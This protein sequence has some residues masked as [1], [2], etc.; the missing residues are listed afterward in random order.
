MVLGLAA[1]GL[2]TLQV[3][4]PPNPSANHAASEP[5]RPPGHTPPAP[6]AAPKPS[7]EP[8]PPAPPPPEGKPPR[9][10]PPDAALLEPSSTGSGPLPRIGADGR[11][12]RLVYAAPAPAARPG[13][14]RVAVVLT[15]VGLSERESRAALDDL[16]A[17]ITLAISAYA[18][19]PAAMIEAARATGHEILASI[20]MEP[21]GYPLNDAGDRSLRAGLSA[22]QNRRNL[23]YVLGRSPGAVGATGASDQTRGEQFAGMSALFNPMLEELGR[24]GLLYVD[25]RPGRRP[26]RNQVPG[27]AVDV[28]PDDP[29]ARAE[30]EAKLILLE[31]LAKE[32]GSAVGLIGPPRPVTIERVATWTKTLEERGL[33]LVPVSALVNP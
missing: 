27:V 7:P 23:E 8:P 30:I 9:P 24:R 3:L 14:A 4:G 21:F 31:R 15:G 20:P 33:V 28:V 25:P 5:A 12:P 1:A 17:A 6:P 32:H 19:N 2:G 11:M 18:G 10:P 16:P 26:P 22:E 29:P 13:A